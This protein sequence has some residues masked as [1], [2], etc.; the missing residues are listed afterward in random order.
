MTPRAT[1]K[2]TTTS[3]DELLI[4]LLRNHGEE[5]SV[6]DKNVFGNFS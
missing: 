6:S 5:N 4:D 3:H 2:S 1:A